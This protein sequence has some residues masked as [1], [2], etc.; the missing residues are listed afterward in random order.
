MGLRDKLWSSKTKDVV[1]IVRLAGSI[2]NGSG[3]VNSKSLNVPALE[4]LL[5]KAFDTKKV[6]PKAVALEISCPGGSAPISNLIYSRIRNLSVKKE[7]PVYSFIEDLAASGGYW[8]AL[9]GDEIYCDP[10]SMVG[11]I[12]ALFANIGLEEVFKTLGLE[13]RLITAGENK[14][15]FD[16]SKPMKDSDRL[17]MEQMLKE[18]HNNFIQL[19]KERRTNLDVDHKTVFT[20]DVFTGSRALQVGLVDGLSS[21]MRVVMQEKYGPDVTFERMTGPTGW[22]A[23]LQKPSTELYFDANKTLEGIH[24]W[25]LKARH[26]GS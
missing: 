18:V 10:N 25:S 8:L 24:D 22:R 21:D 15:R 9:A 23:F 12:G 26:P 5:D 4:K 17:W 1:R 14:F 11:S 2:K 6:K 3:G 7:V 16:P 19:V 20:G 13:F